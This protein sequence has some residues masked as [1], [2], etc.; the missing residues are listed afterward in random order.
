MSNF[1]LLV[2]DGDL[3]NIYKQETLHDSIQKMIELKYLKE[4]EDI[5][6][7]LYRDKEIFSSKGIDD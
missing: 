6:W 3:I 4:R 1:T 5:K 7:I 2:I